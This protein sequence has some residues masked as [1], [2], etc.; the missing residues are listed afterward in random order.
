[1]RNK[2][3]ITEFQLLFSIGVKYFNK[4]TVTELGVKNPQ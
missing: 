2:L 3:L 1:M 4:Q